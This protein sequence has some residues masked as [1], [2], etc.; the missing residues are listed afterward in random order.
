MKPQK[1]R[2]PGRHIP[3]AT[4]RKIGL[5]YLRGKMRVA[6]ICEKF[7]VSVP[8]VRYNAAK[9]FPEWFEAT[10]KERGKYERKSS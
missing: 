5:E 8:T 4:G 1:I 2:E 10:K 7:K 3:E 6:E 9:H